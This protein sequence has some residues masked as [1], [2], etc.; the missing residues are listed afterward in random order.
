MSS[1][2]LRHGFAAALRDDRPSLDDWEA[3]TERYGQDYMSAGAAEIQRRLAGDLLVLQQQ[4]ETP[5]AWAVAARLMTLY[6]KTIPGTDGSKAVAWYRMAATA[7]DRSGDDA[8]RVWVRGR[9][10]IA[11]GYEGNSLPIAQ[12]FAAH[13]LSICDR[14]SLGRLNAVMGDA[15]AAALRGDHATAR[16]LLTEGRRLH[17]AVGSDEQTSDYAVPQWRMGVFCSLLSARL[18]DE[19]A[20]LAA[21]RRRCGPAGVAAAVP[22]PPGAAPRSAARQVR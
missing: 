8:V 1:D 3:R 10:A 17:D 18:G 13:A 5:G 20:A 21:R 12:Q 14:P 9:A 7:A 15:H 6:G 2:L 16:R 19:P 11:L 22:D 4:L